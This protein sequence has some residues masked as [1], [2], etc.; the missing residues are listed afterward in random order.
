MEDSDS[1]LSSEGSAPVQVGKKNGLVGNI[2]HDMSM[3]CVLQEFVEQ[4]SN[5][6]WFG[7][8]SKSELQKDLTQFTPGHQLN[9]AVLRQLLRL[10]SLSHNYVVV[11]SLGLEIAR[12]FTGH[13][14]NDIKG[15]IFPFYVNILDPSSTTGRNHWALGILDLEKQLFTT[16][17]VPNNLS[18]QY[19][20]SL[21]DALQGSN[22]APS[23]LNL[24]LQ[25]VSIKTPYMTFEG[26]SI[27]FSNL[28]FSF[29]Q[30]QTGYH[31]AFAVALH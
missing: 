27:S 11:E 26:C 19:K 3:E 17:D 16:Y 30:I 1:S 7:Y 24:D 21:K 25:S 18:E 5:P 23:H 29:H 12:P 20:S 22:P 13:I 28:V 6:E 31:V 10:I 4:C 2:H 8:R 14:P 9:D 15:L